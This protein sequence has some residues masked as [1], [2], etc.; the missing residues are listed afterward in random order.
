M[1]VEY[2]YNN[3]QKCRREQG[4]EKKLNQFH[5]LETRAPHAVES[6]SIKWN[7]IALSI[8]VLSS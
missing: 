6:V 1:D 3:E 8:G 2:C 4:R 5:C 7:S